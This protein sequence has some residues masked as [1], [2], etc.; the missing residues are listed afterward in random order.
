MWV[1]RGRGSIAPQSRRAGKAGSEEMKSIGE[2]SIATAAGRDFGN[3]RRAGAG[4]RTA[5]G[6]LAQRL[7]EEAGPTAPRAGAPSTASTG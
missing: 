3:S 5:V 6:A 2:M 7:E 4:E 1:R